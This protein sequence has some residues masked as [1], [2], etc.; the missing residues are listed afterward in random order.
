VTRFNLTRLGYA[1]EV[2]D[3]AGITRPP[4]GW[5]RWECSAWLDDGGPEPIQLIAGFPRS[6]PEFPAPRL[7]QH[8]GDLFCGYLLRHQREDGVS[9]FRYQPVQDTLFE[10]LDLVRLAHGA[11]VM[12]RAG[13]QLQRPDLQKSARRRIDLLMARLGKDEEGN[14][15]VDAQSPDASIA[16]I[17]FLL[18]ALCS[19]ELSDQDK[20]TAQK[21]A[22]TLSKQIG[23]HGRIETHLRPAE[24]PESFQDYFPGQLLL[25][26]AAARQAELCSQEIQGLE[27]A[28]RY[29]RHRFRFKRHFGP[30]SWL[31]QA[32]S[33]WWHLLGKSEYAEFVFEVADWVL[34]YQQPEGGFINDHQPDAPGF[35][36]ALYLEGV[37]AALGVAIE[38]GWEE[39]INR[40]RNSLAK[41]FSFLDRLVIQER[42]AA[43]IPN[44]GWALGGLR[45]SATQSEVRIDF[46]QHGLAAALGAL[47]RMEETENSRQAAKAQS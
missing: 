7:I 44:L 43:I 26:L 5:K 29:Y 1:L 23:R 38:A 21:L 41:G 8:L 6:D 28:F 33:A 16:E 35:T 40:C 37:G 14:L 45:R 12:A 27:K 11:W 34:E 15:W 47:G 22:E 30:V 24:D 42:D 18:L 36:T 25:A 19:S 17:S 39:R 3:K 13:R 32:F 10:R 4:Y 46:V 20:Q 31:T 2:I 9:Y